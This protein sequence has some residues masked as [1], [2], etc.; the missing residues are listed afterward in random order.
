MTQ[1][2]DRSKPDTEAAQAIQELR[3]KVFRS[4][5][6]PGAIADLA[7]E[8]N[9]NRSWINKIIQPSSIELVE[10]IER[11]LAGGEPHG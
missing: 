1:R 9:V 2:K 7:D 4:K 8:L 10:K 5:I 6:G 3:R 11:H